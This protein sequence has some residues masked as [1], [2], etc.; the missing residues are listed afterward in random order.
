MSWTPQMQLRYAVVT[1]VALPNALGVAVH[2]RRSGA[3]AGYVGAI[4]DDVAGEL[5]RRALAA[6]AVDTTRLRVRSGPT[7]TATVVGARGQEQHHKNREDGTCLP[8][9]NV[10]G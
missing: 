10:E 6:E 5:I 9:R 4:G 7:A 8:G 1:A 3:Q 2:G